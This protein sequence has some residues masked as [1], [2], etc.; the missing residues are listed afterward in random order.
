MW[1]VIKRFFGYEEELS[2]ALNKPPSASSMPKSS[3]RRSGI[4]CGC[5][6]NLPIGASFCPTCGRPVQIALPVPAWNF[7]KGEE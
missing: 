6:T 2:A 4:E 3:R 7:K 1:K 5:R